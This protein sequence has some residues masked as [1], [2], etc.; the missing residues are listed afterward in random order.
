MRGF[1]RFGVVPTVSI[2]LGSLLVG[3][4]AGE[5]GAGRTEQ[6]RQQILAEVDTVLMELGGEAAIRMGRGQRWRMISSIGAGLPPSNF[7]A[8]D[9]PD[10][11]SRGARLVQAY[12]VQCHWI[13]APQMHSADE[14]PVLVRR[15]ILRAQT[16]HDRMG[17]PVTEGLV[18]EILLSGMA[19]ATVP[20]P[21]DADTL[22]DYMRDHAMPAIDAAELGE[23][24]AVDSYVR[25]CGHCHETPDPGA[26]PA[27]EWEDVV[28]RMRANM[29][30]MSVEPP[31]DREL[32]RIVRFL[33]QR[34][35]SE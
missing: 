34:A 30:L 13:P 16:L 5:E 11:D 27:A 19:S 4:C 20:S 29:F 14:W 3:G 21:A 33:R 32:D 2:V 31:T 8:E 7:Q 35:S 17:G 24:E 25:A 1:V 6:E 23:G 18:G 22:L 15:M 10:P 9:L 12:C 28:G 26:H